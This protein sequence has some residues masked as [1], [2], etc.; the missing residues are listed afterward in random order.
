MINMVLKFATIPKMTFSILQKFFMILIP[1][2]IR[3]AVHLFPGATRN[4]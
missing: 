3:T 4:V 1:D 2:D